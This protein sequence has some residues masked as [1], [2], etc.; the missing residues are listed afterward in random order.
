MSEEKTPLEEFV[1]VY[2]Q[3]KDKFAELPSVLSKLL[4]QSGDITK[5]NVE[6]KSKLK[7][8]ETKFEQ[9][10]T[11]YSTKDTR[12]SDIEKQATEYKTQLEE[13]ESQF[14]A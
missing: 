4:T 12:L 8:I 1:E 5:E 10:Q 13:V 7:E 14:S 2:G 6:L 9:L 11:E 3:I